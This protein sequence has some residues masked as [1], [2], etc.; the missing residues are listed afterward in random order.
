MP[1]GG[2][3]WCLV[4]HAHLGSISQPSQSPCGVGG[5][6][7]GWGDGAGSGA[8]AELLEAGAGRSARATQ[9]LN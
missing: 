9:K 2:C 4:L 3:P 6:L 8:R 7:A 5:A 1:A